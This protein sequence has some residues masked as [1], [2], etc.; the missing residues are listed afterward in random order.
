MFKDPAT[1]KRYGERMDRYATA[2]ACGT[3][4]RIPIRF[5]FQEA[6]AHYAGYTNQQVSC[7]YDLAFE[8]TRRM[9]EDIGSDA[10]MLNAIWGNY[11]VAK[12]AS[13]KYI[14]VPGVDTGTDNV[15]QFSEPELES[16]EYLRFD[17]YEEFI[18]DPT[19]FLF[20]KW[21]PRY[22]T[23]LAIPG[24][25]VTFD[26]NATLISGA[27]AFG[28]YMH[29]FGPAADKLKY[30]SGV[31]NATAGVIKAPFDLL[32]DK[33]RGYLNMTRDTIKHPEMVRKACEALMPHILTNALAGADPDKK[34]PIT[35]WAHR[36]CVPYFNRKTFDE[37]FWPTLKPVFEEVI[38]KGYQILFYSEGNWEA[39][40]DALLELP[41]GSIIYHFDKGDPVRAAKAFKGHFAISGGLP[42][43]VLAHGTTGDVRR[44][45]KELFSVMKPE[46]GYILDCSA[47]M[48]SDINPENIKV[49]VDYTMEHGVY[50]QSSAAI[51]RETPVAHGIPKGKRPAGSVRTWE[52]ESS[53]YACLSGDTELVKRSWQEN[54]LSAYRYLW[55]TAL[56]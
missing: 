10:V 19:G 12:S 49:A 37:I 15:I 27:L 9:A 13:W 53:G 16:E 29:A 23:R 34:V 2:M 4:D 32:T 14:H 40:Y 41:A 1:E 5:L 30:E 52:E 47:L 25:P 21:F 45:M 8:A 31:V 18:D 39:H 38:A 42:Y 28:N 3:P 7:D 44:E 51:K 11:G 22:T 43:D 33:F 24:E 48:L 17:E 56:W 6:A 36:G 35:I 55:T 50:S 20:T 46:G 54:D 26:H